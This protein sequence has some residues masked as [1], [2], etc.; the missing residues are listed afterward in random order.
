MKIRLFKPDDATFCFRI[1]TAAFILKFYEEIGPEAVTAGVNAY[2]PEDYIEMAK[3]GPFFIIE[4]NHRRIGFF[5]IKRND[6]TTAELPL[7]YLDLN[8]LGKGIGSKC[9]RFMEDWIAS[10]WKEVTTFIVDTIIPEYN[11]TFYRKMGFVSQGTVTCDLP[12]MKITAL[13]LSKKMKE[14]S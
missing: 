12:D 1:R 11:G 7:I 2:T 4:E 13:R 3:A 9:V 8:Y 14:R 6:E 5:T 10:N